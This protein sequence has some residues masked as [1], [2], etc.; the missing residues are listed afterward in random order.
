[1]KLQSFTLKAEHRLRV[2]ENRELRK[3]FR[4]KWDEVM[5]LEEIT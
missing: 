5:A 3:V 1:M 2:L 4:P